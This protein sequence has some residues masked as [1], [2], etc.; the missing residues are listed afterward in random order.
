MSNL[1]SRLRVSSGNVKSLLLQAAAGVRPTKSLVRQALFD[2]LRADI[3]DKLF[4]DMFAGSGAVGIEAMS[5]GAGSCVFVE[6]NRKALACLRNNIDKV[7][8][9]YGQITLLPMSV[10]KFLTRYHTKETTIVWAD[11]PYKDQS[12]ES[13]ILSCLQV[14]NNSLFFIEKSRHD[15]CKSSSQRYEAWKLLDIRYYGN[16]ALLI[17]KYEQKGR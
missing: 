6:N 13:K 3:K 8:N 2:I 10:Q 5:N 11:P 15:I 7:S 16:S 14:G 12:W 9:V 4:I 17:F 1:P